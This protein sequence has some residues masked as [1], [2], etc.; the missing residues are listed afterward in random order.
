M[1]KKFT[2]LLFIGI[3]YFTSDIFSQDAKLPVV[4]GRFS[5]VPL[6]RFLTDVEE[7]AP[8]FRFYYD[9]TGLDSIRITVI[10]KGEPLNDVLELAFGGQECTTRLTE[11]IMFL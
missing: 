3:L 7:Q 9:T 4:T 10:T 11:I 6:T 8:G 2:C 5:D 1:I